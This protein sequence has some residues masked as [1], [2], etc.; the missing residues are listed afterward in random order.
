VEAAGLLADGASEVVLVCYDAPLPTPYSAFDDKPAA[1]YAWTWRIAKPEPGQAH[2]EL[3]FGPASGVDSTAGTLSRTLPFG[4]DAM[5]FML[6]GDAF[7]RREADGI[8]WT[9]SR[10]A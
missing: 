2:F 10:H 6:S 4:L 1:T 7:L 5:R 3:G 9:W 8:R